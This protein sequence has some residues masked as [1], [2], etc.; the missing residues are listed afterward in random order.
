MLFCKSQ[1]NNATLQ[2]K[3]TEKSNVYRG[4]AFGYI[5]QVKQPILKLAR[6]S[7]CDYNHLLM[8][9]TALS[10]SLTCRLQ[11][12]YNHIIKKKDF[13][14]ETVVLYV[15]HLHAAYSF[16]EYHKRKQLSR[17]KIF[18]FGLFKPQKFQWIFWSTFSNRL[19][20]ECCL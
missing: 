7:N 9:E 18:T 17:I 10:M 4:I 12:T 3:E 16:Q 15:E 5:H 2:Y 8:L 19:G 11:V 14:T 1:C 20:K 6:V 13:Q